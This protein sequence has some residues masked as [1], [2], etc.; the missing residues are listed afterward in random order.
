MG[1]KLNR[2]TKNLRVLMIEAMQKSYNRGSD[3]DHGYAQGMF[4]AMRIM[5]DERMGRG[6]RWRFPAFLQRE[7]EQ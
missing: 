7:L 5:D 3:Y 2:A 6:K 1:K 4:E